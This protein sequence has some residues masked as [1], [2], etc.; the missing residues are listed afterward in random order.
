MRLVGCDNP[1]P[2]HRFWVTA[3]GMPARGGATGE[4][5]EVLTAEMLALLRDRGARSE[6]GTAGRAER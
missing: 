1:I 4:S 3:I 6:D 2:A 5:V